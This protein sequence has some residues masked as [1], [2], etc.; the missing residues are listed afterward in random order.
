MQLIGCKYIRNFSVA[1][2]YGQLFL[3]KMP[4]SLA[5]VLGTYMIGSGIDFHIGRVNEIR[6]LLLNPGPGDQWM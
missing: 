1:Q 4:G 2:V 6:Y 5:A 3:D